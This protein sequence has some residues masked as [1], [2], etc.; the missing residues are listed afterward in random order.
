MRYVVDEQGYVIKANFGCTLGDCTEYTGEVPEDYETIEDWFEQNCECLKSWKIVDGNLVF[1]N[2]Q[3]YKLKILH[4]QESYDNGHVTRKELGMTSAKE[5]DVY[6][7][8]YPLQETTSHFI[9]QAH[10]NEHKVGNFPVQ[11]VNIKL[12][13]YK[14]IEQL[15][16]EFIEVEFVGQNFLPNTLTS[17]VNNGIEYYQN[18]DRTINITGTATS[19]STINLAGTDTSLKKILTFK[20]TQLGYKTYYRLWGL[21]ERINLEFYYFDGTDRM[22]VGTYNNGFIQFDNDTPVTQIVLTIEEGTT[23][24]TTIKPMLEWETLH[25]EDSSFANMTKYNGE[26]TT[27]TGFYYLDGVSTQETRSGKNKF[28]INE[29]HIDYNATSSITNNTLKII[30]SGN[31]ARTDYLNIEISKTVHTISFNWESDT[32]LSETDARIYIYDGATVGTMLTYSNLVGVSGKVSLTFTNTTGAISIRLSPNNTGTTKTITMNF[33]NIQ[34]EEG[35]IVTEYEA[36]GI[37]PSPD[38]PSEIINLYGGKDCVTI[39]DDKSV[40]LRLENTVLRGLPNGVADRIWID[41]RNVPDSYTGYIERKVGKVVLNGSETWLSYTT[42]TKKG[43]VYYTNITQCKA[44]LSKSISSHFTNV[45]FA[46]DVGN[47]GDFSDHPTLKYKY[48]VSDKATVSEFKTWLSENNVELYYELETY[49]TSETVASNISINEYDEYKNNKTLIDLKGNKLTSNDIVQLRDNQAI[50]IK[51]G[52]EEIY[53]HDISMPRTYTPYTHAYCH[54]YADIQYK[55]RDT[56]II[57][58]GKISFGGAISIPSVETDNLVVGGTEINEERIKEMID[59]STCY[60]EGDMFVRKKDIVLGGYIS[61]SKT[62]LYTTLFLPKRLDKI[63][64]YTINKFNFTIRGITGYLQDPIEIE[65]F[66]GTLTTHIA[67]GNAITFLIKKNTAFDITNNTTAALEINSLEIVFSEVENE[68]TTDDE[69][70]TTENPIVEVNTSNT[71]NGSTS[72]TYWTFKTVVK[73]T[74][75]NKTDKTSTLTV[76]NY[77]G[78]K[79]T[80]GSSYFMGTLTN[81]YECNGQTY[82]ET[83]YK[84]SGTISAGAW[85]KLGSHT[86]T[87]THTQEPMT[88]TV[89]GSMSTSAFNPSS[90]SASGNVTLTQI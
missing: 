16:D 62:T 83:V 55:F 59:N 24:D 82:S 74:K 60:R 4:E 75:I 12:N 26:D 17:R 20:G 38:Y 51:N 85:Y 2:S 66:D 1:D 48:F 45:P 25:N 65:D 76:T 31:Y 27:K 44:G 5:N 37:S 3:D 84:S 77:I 68:T 81:K 18:I 63:K 88:I 56:T 14:D 41:V 7:D 87:V 9:S 70:E 43:Y 35:T 6:N 32:I 69:E 28:D 15:D 22:L 36:F 8:I 46:W 47:I 54:Q 67:S 90:A 79:S 33:N 10:E 73:E 64:S 19:K 61:T 49:D 52:V 21:D 30:T 58:I 29:T 34:I 57:D 80:A 50:F 78:R 86:F 72:S 89:K 42:G 11:E 40:T 13:E 71:I 39:C 53:L 23:I